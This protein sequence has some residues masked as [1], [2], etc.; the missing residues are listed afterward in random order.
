MGTRR[1]W[2][3]ASL[4]AATLLFGAHAASAEVHFEG[5][6]QWAEWEAGTK[7]A[8]AKKK[9]LLLL[10]FTDSCPKCTLLGHVFRDNKAVHKLAKQFVMVHVNA[11]SAPMAIVSRFARYGN[12]AP[13]VLFLRPDTSPVD[14]I[15]S[16]NPSFPYYYQPSRPELL[17]AAMEKA[18]ALGSAAGPAKDG[19]GAGKRGAGAASDRFIAHNQR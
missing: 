19:K 9:P 5:P 6:I 17:I 8:A 16:G 1:I 15:V 12:Y 3:W 13:R 7:Q 10:L 11:G 14:A 2:H 4:L 18:K